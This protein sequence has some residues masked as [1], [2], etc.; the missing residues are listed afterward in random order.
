MKTVKRKHFFFN[1]RFNTFFLK[2][3][4][5]SI[6]IEFALIFPMFIA[7]FMFVLEIS[8][9]MFI[10]SALDLVSSQVGRETTI[11]ENINKNSLTYTNIYEEVLAREI[12]GWTILASKDNFKIDVQYCNTIKDVINNGCSSNLSMTNKIILF[13]VT[14]S[15]KAIFPS[16]FSKLIDASLI[17]KVV[18]YREFYS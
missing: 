10:G 8:R 13:N 7:L 17:K 14:Y 9:V 6:S 12:P 1:C 16:L 18:V 2:E 4:K 3:K 11:T 15:Y 5:G